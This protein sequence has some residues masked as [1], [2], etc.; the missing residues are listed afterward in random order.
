[1]G[2]YAVAGRSAAS[3]FLQGMSQEDIKTAA[4]NF[5][6]D[7]VDQMNLAL[8]IVSGKS[9]V[10]YEDGVAVVNG[11]RTGMDAPYVKQNLDTA[12]KLLSDNNIKEGFN[13]GLFGP[14]GNSEANFMYQI[15][16]NITKG[17]AKGVEDKKAVDELKGAI[18]RVSNAGQ[19][20]CAKS[21]KIESPSKVF[22]KFG[23]F[24][25]LGLAKGITDETQAAVDAMGKTSN[26]IINSMRETINKANDT[27]I[28]DV[29]EPVITPVLDLSEIQDGSRQLNNMLSRNSAFSAGRSFS[30]LQNEQWN[31]QSALL[32]ATMDNTDVVSAISTLNDE[33]TTLKDVMAN[34]KVVLDTGTMVGAMTPAID[35]QLGVMQVYA[36]RGI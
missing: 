27:L 20:A 13:K 2:S 14:G 7:V 25:T 17:I 6:H 24:I 19:D 23:R 1:Y 12:I 3:G 15:G 34:I 35:Q 9:M 29:D 22:A 18:V 21:N 31:S 5:A 16:T 4:V 30:N 11:V 33:V 8:D 32:N 28:N 36:G 10:T 26:T